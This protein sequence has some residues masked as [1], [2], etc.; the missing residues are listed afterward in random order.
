MP[1]SKKVSLLLITSLTLLGLIALIPTDSTSSGAAIRRLLKPQEGLILRSFF[2]A[3]HNIRQILVDLISNE[4]S[5]LQIA[6]FYLTD[7]YIANAI[8][9]AHQRGVKVAIITEAQHVEKC[10]STKIFE[11]HQAK[12]PIKVFCSPKKNGIMHHKFALFGKNIYNHAL[13]ASGSFNYTAGASEGNRENILITNH[14]ET[15]NGYKQEFQDLTKI[16]I[17]LKEFINRQRSI[18]NDSL[19]DLRWNS[20]FSLRQP[21]LATPS[22]T[23]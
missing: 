13:L 16:A 2:T 21:S 23:R 20:E 1:K 17:D 12:V 11:L 14:T 15:I 10:V 5:S 3:R 6:I 7:A 4:Q 22:H 9:K 19:P 18:Q 8:R